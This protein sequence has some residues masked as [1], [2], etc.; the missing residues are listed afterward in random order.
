MPRDKEKDRA[1]VKKW[2]QE[3]WERVKEIKRN[4][5]QRNRDGIRNKQRDR[6]PSRMDREKDSSLKRKYGI[7]LVDYKNILSDQGDV[8]AICG[9]T[10]PDCGA[11][12]FGNKRRH[13]DVDHCHKTGYVRGIL[14]TNCNKVIGMF[15]DNPDRFLATY[16]YLSSFLNG[17]KPRIAPKEDQGLLF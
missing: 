17:R 1:R 8:C 5:A 11:V 10:N 16:K 6:Y 4:H 3:N 14:C 2:H 9:E 12:A 13:F 7:T 15:K